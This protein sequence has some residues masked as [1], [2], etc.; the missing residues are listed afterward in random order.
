MDQVI[1]M[2]GAMQHKL[3]DI[4]HKMYAK[5]DEVVMKQD[6]SRTAQDKE[7]SELEDAIVNVLDRLSGAVLNKLV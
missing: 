1:K 6:S 2:N 7:L 5:L 3:N 4:D